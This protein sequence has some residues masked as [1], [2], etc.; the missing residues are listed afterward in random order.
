MLKKT[1]IAATLAAS[2]LSAE[3]ASRETVRF[4]VD[5]TPL[6]GT[7]FRPDNAKTNQRLPAIIV[8][9]P[10]TQVKEQ[11]GY[12][13][14][15]RLADAGYAVLTLDHRNFGQSGGTPRQFEDPATKVADL[16]AA[17]SHLQTL[18]GVDGQRIY[19]LGVC[20]GASLM[21]D[22]ARQDRRLK[23]FATVAAWMHDADSLKATFGAEGLALR[24]KTGAEALAAY[25]QDGTVTYIPA[26]ANDVP[27]A[28]MMGPLDYYASPAR[29]AIPAWDNRFA[30][31]SFTGWLAHE[32]AT[33]A[34]QITQPVLMI[35][36]DGS[37]LPE[38]VRKFHAAL[39]NAQKKLVWTTGNHLDFYDQPEL[40]QPAVAEVASYFKSL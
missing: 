25:R 22:L 24:T 10:W 4:T 39:P 26:F 2:A 27:L 1:L 5:G 18:P 19:G 37:A 12:A 8:D 11:V 16:K 13:Y 28:A 20:Y 34:P 6:V 15:P 14:A 9:G 33:Y 21:A 7:L 3:A 31:M 38:N 30:A 29:G 23:A 36:S 32:A 35:H 40:V 17:I